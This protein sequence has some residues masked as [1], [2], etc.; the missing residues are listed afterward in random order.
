MVPVVVVY[1]VYHSI[2]L[3]FIDEQK[4]QT[5]AAKWTEYYEQT[6]QSPLALASRLAHDVCRYWYL[7]VGI[8]LIVKY[9]GYATGLFAPVICTGRLQTT[10]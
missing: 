5:T 8:I 7:R 2:I 10:G 1:G 3:I 4:Q 6:P 9:P